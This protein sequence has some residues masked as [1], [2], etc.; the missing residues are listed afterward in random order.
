VNIRA[1]TGFLDPGWPLDPKRL[2]AAAACLANARQ[3]LGEAGYT[4]QTLRLATPPPQE[5]AAP[6][7]VI[8]FASGLSFWGSSWLRSSASL[9][10]LTTP[11]CRERTSAADIFR[12]RLFLFWYG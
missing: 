12:W 3:A 1:L 5:K 4:V 11:I 9:P 2:A 8:A 7:E 10:L 6:P